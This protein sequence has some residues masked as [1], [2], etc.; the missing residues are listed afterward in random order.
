MAFVTSSSRP[1]TT[2]P[3]GSGPSLRRLSSWSR[4]VIPPPESQIL[5]KGNLFYLTF[6]KFQTLRVT[7]LILS[8]FIIFQ[9]YN[10]TENVLN[11]YFSYADDYVL[12]DLELTVADYVQRAMKA[13]FAA[14]WDEL[15]PTNELEE[16]YAL[17]SVKTLE[18]GVKNIIQYLGLQPCERSDKIPDG[19]SSH[20][21]FLAGKLIGFFFLKYLNNS[22]MTKLN[23]Q[24]HN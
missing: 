20:T 2:S 4:I 3:S 19:K 7:K 6:S 14:A 15:G 9:C 1:P 12:E 13:N 17:S 24:H 10:Y 11:I 8:C 5:T 22:C 21:L 16:T 18:E 23:N